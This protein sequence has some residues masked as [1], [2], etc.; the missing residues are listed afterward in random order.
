M[1]RLTFAALLMTVLFTRAPLAAQ[2]GDGGLVGFVKDEQGGILPG[3]VLTASGPA[4]IGVR[5]ATSDSTGY[6][7]L[8]NLPPGEYTLSPELSGFATLRR[9]G[10]LVR[11]GS[12]FS[13]D[14]VMKVGSLQETLT[15]RGDAPML[16]WQTPAAR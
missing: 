8:V 10:L 7:R 1:A 14:I 3:V 9:E 11:A 2:S 15:V 12:T 16:E 4:L 13:V 6:Y 5:T